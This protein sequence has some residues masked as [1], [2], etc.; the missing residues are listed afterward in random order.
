MP[1]WRGLDGPAAAVISAEGPR[2]G[3]TRGSVRHA[4][5]PAVCGG[6]VG[7]AESR[8]NQRNASGV[9]FALASPATNFQPR[10]T[11]LLDGQTRGGTSYFTLLRCPPSWESRAYNVVFPNSGLSISLVS[12]ASRG[13]SA[14]S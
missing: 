14:S 9:T 8:L 12:A 1:S 3:R 11:Y 2:L 4:R 5:S 13:S 7:G 10:Y 6:I